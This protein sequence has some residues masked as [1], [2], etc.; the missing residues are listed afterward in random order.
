MVLPIVAV[1]MGDPAGIGPE[2]C[3]KILKEPAV[4][5]ICR[6]VVFGDF[7]IVGKVAG[8]TA[9]ST[10]D[11]VI[12]LETWL[13]G[14]VPSRGAFIDV[15]AVKDP[16]II[17]PGKIDAV[18][19]KAAYEYIKLAVK[20]TV[21]KKTAAVITG[22]INKAALKLAGI[23][24]PGHTEMIAEMTGSRKYCMMLASDVITV[25]LATIHISYSD[26]ATHLTTENI[27]DAI[28]LTADAMRRVGRMNPRLTVC[29]LNP[30][31]GENGLFGTEEA[32][33]IEPAIAQARNE[34]LRVVG[35]VPPDTAFV[36]AKR[37]QT[38]AYVVMYHDQGLIPFKMLAFETGINV[39]LGLSIVRTSPDHGT[40]FDIAWQGKASPVSMINAI[41]WAVKLAGGNN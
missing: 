33:I 8:I 32:D 40:A 16:S 19:G 26:V 37:A 28:R 2:L 25:S 17:V 4:T 41:K 29:G 23:F 15:K 5:Q 6:P 30:H 27:L 3:L 7:S 38:D 13:Q 34:G 1:T 20:A 35:P 24:Y 39:T 21:E 9:A 36:P 31:G 12:S 22:P 18:C 10:P 11:C 14:Y